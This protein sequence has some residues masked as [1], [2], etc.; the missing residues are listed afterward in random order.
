[1]VSS[2]PTGASDVVVTGTSAHRADAGE[3]KPCPRYGRGVLAAVQ[4]LDVT[5]GLAPL[6]PPVDERPPEQPQRRLLAVGQRA[7]F[8][9]L[10]LYRGE[11]VATTHTNSDVRLILRERGHE[12]PPLFSVSRPCPLGGR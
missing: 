9:H 2:E 10:L 6:T 12:R 5:D 3:P 11:R 4:P 8:D 1:M 7:R